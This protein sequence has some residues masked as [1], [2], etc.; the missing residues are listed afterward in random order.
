MS[1]AAKQKLANKIV[2]TALKNHCG[3]V[4]QVSKQ[5]ASFDKDEYICNMA[6]KAKQVQDECL[7][8]H[9]KYK[10]QFFVHSSTE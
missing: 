1:P 7:K 2:T 5:H 8:K 3:V 10:R 9:E 6:S 4:G